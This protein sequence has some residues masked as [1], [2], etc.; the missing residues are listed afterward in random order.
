MDELLPLFRDQYRE[1]GDLEQ[2]DLVSSLTPDTVQ[3]F[4]RD[5]SSDDRLPLEEA[6]QITDGS[7]VEVSVEAQQDSVTTAA[8]GGGA[9]AGGSSNGE[10]K[11]SG[12]EAELLRREL[13]ALKRKMS[14]L[15]SGK[16]A[17]GGSGGGSRDGGRKQSEETTTETDRQQ[18]REQRSSSRA[19][20]SGQGIRQGAA[21]RLCCRVA[22]LT[23]RLPSAP[24]ALL[25]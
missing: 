9:S 24:S 7:V 15:E 25:Q 14:A 8:A 23:V 6:G 22:A 2:L 18:S 3:L 4:L 12:S 16:A 17:S 20:D 11:E 1:V 10:A 5:P 19:E 13:E 21:P